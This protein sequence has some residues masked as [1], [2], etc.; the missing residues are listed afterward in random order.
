MCHLNEYLFSFQRNACILIFIHDK[1][2]YIKL[3]YPHFLLNQKTE[4]RITIKISDLLINN[5]IYK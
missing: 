4:I 5:N 3:L 1:Q 2:I